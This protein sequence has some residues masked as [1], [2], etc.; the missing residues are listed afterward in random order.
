MKGAVL[1]IFTAPARGAP[2]E[3]QP[4]VTAVAETGLSGDRYTLVKNRR[5]PKYQVTLIEI[6]HIE[7][8]RQAVDPSFS[9][10]QPRR[11]IVTQGVP[12]NSLCGKRFRVG[13]AEFEGLEL[14]EPCSLMARR[15]RRD[16]LQHFLHRGGLRARIISGGAISPGDEVLYASVQPAES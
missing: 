9:P 7:A 5:G 16:V 11:N 2:M 4:T 12:L 8:Y 15:I 6:E 13:G 3:S 1:H 14:C 10:D